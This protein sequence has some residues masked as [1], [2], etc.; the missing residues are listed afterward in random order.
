MKIVL[1]ELLNHFYINTTVF[2]WSSFVFHFAELGLRE[3]LQHSI[4]E[5]ICRHFNV[6]MTLFPHLQHPTLE[7]IRTSDFASIMA[8]IFV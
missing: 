8:S 6:A 3:S 4:S 5:C 1:F 2:L 7:E